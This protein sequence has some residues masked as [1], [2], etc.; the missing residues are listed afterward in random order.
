VTTID[1][2]RAHHAAIRANIDDWYAGRIDHA[3]FTERARALHAAAEA[4][5]P[6]VEEA[7]CAQLLAA[8]PGGRR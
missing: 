5:G 6:A 1:R 4:D 3:T 7:L 2:A 8:L